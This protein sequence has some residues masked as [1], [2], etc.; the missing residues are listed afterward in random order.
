MKTINADLTI[1]DPDFSSEPVKISD[2]ISMGRTN[3]LDLIEIGK[4]A[5]QEM[6]SI[7]DQSQHPQSYQVLGGLINILVNANKE[8]INLEMKR[9]AIEEKAKAP[10]DTT[11][12]NNLIITSEQ[13]LKMIKEKR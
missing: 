7:A 6:A 12:N 13:L 2:D 3:I 5:T 4:T 1:Y 11:I 8:L 9:Q 10:S